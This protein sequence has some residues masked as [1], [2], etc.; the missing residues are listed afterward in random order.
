M[1]NIPIIKLLFMLIPIFIVWFFYVKWVKG[2]IEILIAT[3]RMTAQL[4]LIGYALV[5]ILRTESLLISILIISVMI[6]S[7]SWI[8]QGN[9]QD[10]SFRAYRDITLAIFV[11]GTFNLAFVIGLVLQVTPF[12]SPQFLIPLAGMIYANAMNAV[13]LCAERF[14]KEIKK[15]DYH[16]ARATAFSSAIIPQVNT[17]LAVG[18]VSLP[19][20]M[21]GQ[22]LSGIDPIIAVR[23]Q[24]MVMAMVLGSGG[25]SIIVYLFLKGRQVIE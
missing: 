11:G 21:T 14:E 1:Y 7:S 8:T 24:I 12:Y 9:I 16:Q 22:I 6:L 18:L 5:Y 20:M 25:M 23:Y 3:I 4:L 10:Q 13:S 2:S 19:G 15:V 17:F